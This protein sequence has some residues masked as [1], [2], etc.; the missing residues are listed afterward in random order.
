MNRPNLDTGPRT[1][2]DDATPAFLAAIEGE[3]TM[4]RRIALLGAMPL[5]AGAVLLAT[6]GGASAE[7]APQSSCVAQAT[8]NMGPPGQ[9]Q[10]GGEIVKLLAHLPNDSC[11]NF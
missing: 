3:M 5:A 4:G 1:P 7:P 9:F 10:L 11:P 6:A 8:Y 2:E